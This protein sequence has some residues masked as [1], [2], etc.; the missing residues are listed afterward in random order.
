MGMRLAILPH[1]AGRSAVR[2]IWYSLDGAQ[3]LP[4][5]SLDGPNVSIPV[6]AEGA[7]TVTFYAEDEAGNIEAP[8]IYVVHLDRTKPVTTASLSPTS[9]E[10]GWNRTSPVTV[11]L[12][13]T[14]PGGPGVKQIKYSIGAGTPVVVQYACS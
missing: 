9:N 14:D 7:T 12:T 10:S 6:P 11:T 8:K 3:S 13:A 2:R 4:F 1:A 5:T